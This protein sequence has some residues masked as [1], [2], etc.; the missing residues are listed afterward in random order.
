MDEV[1]NEASTGVMASD[2][3]R[4]RCEA[5]G[6]IIRFLTRALAGTAVFWYDSVNAIVM[7]AIC[8]STDEY[9]GNSQAETG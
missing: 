6:F 9:R 7:L 1:A 2:M 8:E 3:N 4:L 5:D